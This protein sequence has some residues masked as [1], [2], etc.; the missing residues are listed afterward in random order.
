MR[1]T[2][3]LLISLLLV[4]A[5]LTQSAPSNFGYTQTPSNPSQYS[6]SN[7]YE[8]KKDYRSAPN[9]PQMR[10]EETEMIVAIY[11]AS[12]VLVG[13]LTLVASCVLGYRCMKARSQRNQIKN[14]MHL[15]KHQ[16]ATQMGV[17]VFELDNRTGRTIHL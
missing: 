10:D 9:R 5:A 13:I 15:R 16:F 7:S 4:G 6:Y 14:Q 12:V 3:S 17:S 1:L 8:N 2:Y 11:S